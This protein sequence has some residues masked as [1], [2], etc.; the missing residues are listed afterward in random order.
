MVGVALCLAASVGLQVGGPPPRKYPP[1]LTDADLQKLPPQQV[2]DLFKQV[3][4]PKE[5][6]LP[7]DDPDPDPGNKGKK[8]APSTGEVKHQGMN[9]GP[10]L[11]CTVDLPDPGKK[12]GDEAGKNAILR[13]LVVKLPH[14]LTVC[15][16][17]DTLAV[18]AAWQG[19]FLDLSKTNHE[20]SKGMMAAQVPWPLWFTNLETPGWA[21]MD[22]KFADPRQPRLGPLPVSWLRYRGHYLHGDRVILKY[23]VQGREVLEM[24]GAEKHGDELLLTRTFRIEPSD[25]RVELLLVHGNADKKVVAGF[26]EDHKLRD[27]EIASPHARNGLAAA[28]AVSGKD[29]GIDLGKEKVAVDPAKQALSFKVFFRPKHPLINSNQFFDALRQSGPAE[30]LAKLLQGGPNRWGTSLTTKGTLGKP[31]GKF[32]YVVDTLTVPFDNPYK[33]WMRIAAL[34]FFSDGRLA[35]S[36]LDGDVWIVSGIDDNLGKLTWQRFATGLYEP[37]GLRIV[38]DQV[39]VLGRDRITRL[40]DL[41]GDGEADFYESFWHDGNVAPSFHAFSFDLQTDRAGNFYFVKSGRRVEKE[42]PGHGALIKVT[43]DGKSSEVLATGFRHPNGMGVG[44]DDEVVVSDNQGEWVPASKVSLIRPGG[45]YGYYRKDEKP[46][47]TYDL[48]L[49]WLPMDVDNS[50][51]GQCWA[52]TDKWGALSGKLLHTS[53]G[54]CSLMYVLTQKVG[55]SYNAAVAEL[56]FLF[57]SGVMRARVNPKDGQ[58]YVCGLRGWQTKAQDVGCVE[59]VRWTGQKR[60]LVTGVEFLPGKVRIRFSEPVDPQSLKDPKSYKLTQWNYIW[61]HYYGSPHMSA[62]EPTK[63][64]HNTVAFAVES[65]RNDHR[66]VVLAVPELQPVH[67]M[68]L[69]VDVRGAD[70]VQLRQVLYATINAVGE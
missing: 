22:G 45:F 58:V 59:R 63:V 13:G 51:G 53:Y 66:E 52:T 16:D 61:S 37:L 7:E 23:E 27:M 50:S 11:A 62:V 64:G 38:K 42:R 1:P 12:K 57:R 69:R 26:S 43:A 44:P 36:T 24:P 30:D 2:K 15:Y 14:D 65:I 31:D 32:P 49:F 3:A 41:N 4:L 5:V 39:Y 34:D 35:V 8:G 33:S 19:G 28:I 48:P 10:C 47:T 29:A 60:S 20:N 67:Q 18:A 54:A 6:A 56:P 17:L 68:R 70:G 55:A 25:K 46:G 40:H 9:Y 21:D